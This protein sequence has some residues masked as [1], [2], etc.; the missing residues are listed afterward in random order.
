MSRYWVATG[1]LGLGL[2]TTPAMAADLLPSA[3]SPTGTGSVTYTFGQYSVTIFSCKEATNGTMVSGDCGNEQVVGTVTNNG[4]LVLTYESAAG[5]SLLN[6]TVG[7][8]NNQD[9]SF[10]ETVSTSGKLI[11]GVAL[12]LTGAVQTAANSTEQQDVRTSMTDSIAG[13]AFA[14]NTNMSNGASPYTVTQ[15]IAPTNS[16]TISKDLAAGASGS[17]TG[18]TI[19]LKTVS[20]TF[21]V[22]EPASMSLLAVGIGGLLGL[23]RRRR[24]RTS[25]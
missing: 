6:T 10:T 2:L 16:M 19:A 25:A 24:A 13:Q 3:N 12:G 5:S 21:N 9:M 22:P 14:I 1:L 18:D 11:N 20:Q 7:S 4:S 8:G 17:I 23:R 15:G